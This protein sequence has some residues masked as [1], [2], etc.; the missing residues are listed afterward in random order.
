MPPIVVTSELETAPLLLREPYR[1]F[2]PL[3]V[4]LAAAGVGHWLLHGLGVL[5]DYRP[6]FH[7]MTQVQGFLLCFAL[8]FLFTMIPRRTGTAPPSALTLAIGA[9]G[10]IGTVVA[11]AYGRWM[12]SQV[13]FLIVMA[14]LLVFIVGR[15]V[16]ATAK[17]RPPSSFVWI[18]I[19]FLMGVVGSVLTG[20]AG[21][22]G[23]VEHMR[24]HDI[25]RGLVL[26]GMVLGLVLG[27]GG[28]AI[29]LMT[30]G[31]APRDATKADRF[32]RLGHLVAA[33]ALVASFVFMSE[34]GLRGAYVVRATVAF[35]MLFSVADLHRPPTKP[36]INRWAIWIAAWM[37]P[38]GYLLAA[39]FPE[40]HKAG[41][42]VVFLGGFSM[43]TLAVSTQVTLGHGGYTELMN[44]RPLAVPIFAAALL[45]AMVPR[46]LMEWDP[47]HFFECMVAAAAAFLLAALVWAGFLL[48]KLW[49]AERK[50]S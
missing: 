2:F 49:S 50:S 11:A 44:G 40:Q 7:A 15:F 12:I 16:S 43:L 35:V 37:I 33:A 41:L 13:F 23:M 10:P 42:H 45:V 28:L 26:Q 24:L 18:P 32:V 17:R 36:G 27:V 14:T 46:A 48:P 29:P 30:R 5:E 34:L 47:D 31:E 22:L 19:A 6:V 4:S 39:I 3:G 9:I 8:G 25:G 38:L 20:V 1:L 21:A